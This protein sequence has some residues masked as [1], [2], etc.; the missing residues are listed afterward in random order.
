MG[1]LPLENESYLL[2]RHRDRSADSSLTK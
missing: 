1:Y 2:V